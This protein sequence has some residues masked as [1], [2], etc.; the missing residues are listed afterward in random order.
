MRRRLALA[1]LF[2]LGWP[3]ALRAADGTLGSGQYRL[4]GASFDIAP[5]EQ[6]VPVGVSATVKTIFSGSV[7]ALAAA[8]ARVVAELSGPGVPSPV[9]I[10]AAPGEDLVVPSLSI[11]GEHRLDHIRLT[12]GT[13]AAVPAAH[14]T[15]RIVVSDIFVTQITS[16]ALTSQELAARGVVVND[17]NYKA[18]SFALGLA[19]QGRTITIE[20]P[21]VVQTRDGYQPLGPPTV[22][23]ENRDERFVPPT[24]I[25][26][27]LKDDRPASGPPD[28]EEIV[29]DEVSPQPVFGLL[30]FPGNI[31]F[32]NQFFSVVLMVQNGSAAGSNLTLHDVRATISRPAASLRLAKTI[33]AVPDGSPVPVRAAGPDGVLGTGDDVSVLVAQA[34]G[35]AEFVTEGLRVGTHEV[36]CELEATLEGLANQAPRRLTGRARGSVLVR[37]PSFG[38][39]FNHPDVIRSGEEYELRVTVANTSTVVA[40]HVSISIDAASLTGA[41]PVDLPQGVDPSAQLGD[42]PPGESRLAKFTLRATRT[43]RV[44]ASAFTS[45]GSVVGSLRLRTGVTNDGI[46]LSPDSFVF[47][48]FVSLLPSAIVDPATALIG[49]AHGLATVDPTAPGLG[50][51]LLGE[52]CAAP[53]AD[54]VVRNRVSE[55]VAA[56]RRAGLGEPIP[57]A[58]AD[59]AFAWL[60]GAV[61]SPGFDGV[62][63]SNDHGKDFEAGIG[64]VLSAHLGAAGRSELE[65]TLLDAA[66]ANRPADDPS[67]LQGGP[68]WAILDEGSPTDPTARLYLGDP[69][70]GALSGLRPGEAGYLRGA[71]FTGLFS[72]SAAEGSEV[73]IVAR[74]RSSGVVLG[75][76]GRRTGAVGLTVFFPDGAGGFRRARFDGIA[77]AAGSVTN[78]HVLS[79]ATQLQSISATDIV[80]TAP[81][82]EAPPS[83]FRPYGASQDLDANPL[84]KAVSLVFNRPLLVGRASEVER[85][86]L[87]ALR[88]DGSSYERGVNGAFAQGSDPRHVILVSET[89][90]SP[91]RPGV[92]V[93]SNVP[94]RDGSLW[95][96]TLPITPK[97]DRPGGT[98]SGRV[99]GPDGTPLPN[100]QVRLSESATD[101][102]S[103]EV[104]A[105]TTSVTRTDATGAFVFDY[106]RKQDGRPFR[107]DSFDAL[108]GSKGF[109][110]G[111]IRSQGQSVQVDVVLQGRGTVRGTVVDGNGAVLPGVI[112]RCSSENDPG[113]RTAQLSLAD[114]SF[115][116]LS[117]PVGAVRLQAEDPI[118]NRT[119]YA[120]VALSA[121]GAV[122]TRQ[123]VLA[124]LPRTSL[125]GVVLHGGDGSPYGNVYVAG[126]GQL[127]EYFGVRLTEADGRF[128]FASA[129]AGNVRLELFDT[130]ISQGPILVQ[131]VTLIGDQPAE[132]TLTFVETTPSFGTVAGVVR[133]V[134][135]GASAPV[136]GIVVYARSTG[137]RTTTTAEGAYRLDGIPIGQQSIFALDPATGRSVSGSTAVQQGLISTLD[138]Q[139]ADATRGSVVG[140]VLDQRGQPKSGVKV[141]IFDEGPPIKVI[142][143]AVTAADGSFTLLD[144]PPGTL[145]VQATM[146]EQRGSLTLRNAGAASANLP[147]AG[148]AARVTILLRGWVTVTG[149]VVARVRDRNGDLHDNPVFAPVELR[150]SRFSDGLNDPDPEVGPLY[151]DGP[152]P[153]STVNTD[154]ETGAFRFENVHGGPIRVVVRNPF[155]GEKAQDLGFVQGDTSRGPVELAFD[156][157]LGIV[158]GYLF[159]ADGTPIVGGHLTLSGEGSLGA[160]EAT[161][162]PAGPSNDA[163]YFIFPLV[164]FSRVIRLRFAEA[165]NG[166]DRFAEGSVSISAQAPSARVTLRALGV[167]AVNVRVVQPSGNDLVP[168]PGAQVR[169][170]ELRG[171]QRS[172]TATADASGTATFS[173]VTEGPV[174]ALARTGL[175]SGRSSAFGS[176]E[177]FGLD[178]VVRITGTAR[179]LGSVRIP[180]DGSPAPNVNIVLAS[181][182]GGGLGLGPLAAATTAADGS[183]DIPDVPAVSG[184]VY[185]VD[186]EDPGS[187]RRGQSGTL[188]LGQGDEKRADITLNALGAVTGTLTTFD[189]AA[190]IGG[191]EI[192]VSSYEPIPGSEHARVTELVASTD[193]HGAYRVDGVP[194]GT[195][196]VRSHDDLTGLSASGSGSLSAEGQ[197]VTIDLRATPTGRVRGV[198][199]K[200]D[201]T[202]LDAA[203]AAPTV[204]LDSSRTQVATTKAYDFT[205]VDAT[206]E[207]VLEA[208]EPVGPFHSATTNGSVSPGETRTIDLRYGPFG[209]VRVHL[210]KPDPAS[211]GSFLP[212]VGLVTIYQGGP[213]AGRFPSQASFRTDGQ[214]ELTIVNVGGGF[215]LSVRAVEDATGAAG[216]ANVA[217]FTADGQVVDATIVVEPRGIVRGRLL[218]PGG[219]SPASGVAVRLYLS[220]YTVSPLSPPGATA[221]AVADALGL[222]ELR[223][224]PF[225]NFFVIA[226]TTT[227]LSRVFVEGRLTAGAPV[228]DLGDLVLDDSAP[229]LVAVDPP[230]GS[231]GLGLTPAI[232]FIFSEPLWPYGSDG[233]WRLTQFTSSTGQ[234]LSGFQASQ[235]DTGRIVTIRPTSPLPGNT[236]FEVRLPGN[237]RDR[238]LLDVGADTVTRFTTADLTNP[239]VVR[240][241]PVANQVQVGVQVNPSVVLSKAIDPATIGGGTHL[242]RLDAPSGPVSIS[243]AL[244][245]DGRTIVLNASANLEDE[246]EY[247]IVLDALRDLAGNALHATTRI[248]FFTRDDRA[249]GPVFDS[250]DTSEPVEGTIHDYTVRFADDDVKTV[251]LWLVAPTGEIWN[252]TSGVVSPPRADRSVTCTVRLPRISEAGGASIRARTVATDFGGNSSA[253]VDLP[254]TLRYDA[255]PTIVSAAA[256]ASTVKVG[257]SFAVTV[258]ASD[259]QSLSGIE[260]T[261][262]V[263]LEAVSTEVT[264]SSPTGRTEVRTYRAAPGAVPGLASV[265]F[266]ARDSRGQLSAATQVSVTIQADDPPT[267]TII[268]PAA[269]STILAGSNVPVTFRVSD[270]LGVAALVLELGTSRVTVPGPVGTGTASLVAPAVAS[271]QALDLT[272][273]ATDTTGHVVRATTPVTIRPDG[274]PVVVVTAPSA[275]LHVKGGS[276]VPVSGSLSDDNDRATLTAN[277][278]ASS[279]TVATVG[280][281][282]FTLGVPVVTATTSMNLFVTAADDTGHVADPVAIGLVVDP[283]TSDPTIAVGS[284]ADGSTVIGGMAF[285]LVATASDDVAVTA[286]R[287]KVNG[288]AFSAVSGRVIAAQIAAPAVASPTP[289]AIV[290]EA[291]DGAGHVA[292]TAIG[293]TVVPNQ[294]PTLTILQPTVDA[295]ITAG[296][297]F[298]VSGRAADDSGTPTTAVTFN[299]TTKSATG[300]TFSV[301]FTAPAVSTETPATILASAQDPEGN[302]S[303]PV[304]VTV[305]VVPDVGGTPTIRLADSSPSALLVGEATAVSIVYA[306]NVGL[307]SGTAEVTGAFTSGPRTFALS[308][309]SSS[310][311]IDVVSAG[312]PFGDSA[313]VRAR[314]VDLGGHVATLDVTLPVAY[315]R[316]ELPLP[317]GPVTEGSPLTGVFRLSPSGRQRAA[318]LRLEIGTVSGQTFTVVACTQRNAPLAELETVFVPVPVGRTGL[319]VRSVLVETTGAQALAARTDGRSILLDPLATAGDTVSPVVSITSPATGTAVLAGDLVTVTVTASDDTRIDRIDVEFGGITKTCVVSPC[320]L[321]FFAPVVATAGPR[322][323]FATARDG[324]GKTATTSVSLTVSPRPGG[325]SKSG[326][327]DALVR[328][329]GVAPAIR[330]LTPYVSPAPVAPNA[331][332][333]PVFESADADGIARIE[334]YLDGGEVPCLVIRPSHPSREGCLVPDGPAGER[335][336]LRAVAYDRSGQTGAIETAIVVTPG[337]RFRQAGILPADRDVSG[338]TLYVETETRLEA[339]LVVDNLVVRDGGRLSATPGRPLTVTARH[340]VF[341]DTGSVVSA[342]GAGPGPSAVEPVLDTR[343]GE[344]GAHGGDAGSRLAFDSFLRPGWPGASGGDGTAGADR[345]SRGGGVIAIR[346]E[347]VVLAGTVEA[348]GEPQLAV[349]TG[350]IGAGGSVRIEAGSSIV[351]AHG[352]V[353]GT[354]YALV[355]ASGGRVTTDVE[356]E[357]LGAG[358]RIALAAPVVEVVDVDVAGSVSPTH[359]GGAGTVYVRDESHTNGRLLL[360]GGLPEPGNGRPGSVVSMPSHVPSLGCGRLEP[361]AA[362]RCRTPGRAFSLG[363]AGLWIEVAGPP[364]VRLRILDE[365]PDGFRLDLAGRD[366]L[367]AGLSGRA[368]C[369][370]VVLD[371]LHMEDGAHAVF[372]DRLEVP[373]QGISIDST[374]SLEQP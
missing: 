364:S 70:T 247:E 180:A 8:G 231:A 255:P 151:K 209:S 62:R 96:G 243:P 166:I 276:T 73:G 105:A 233:L 259:D 128:S 137:Q 52:D 120:T 340:E 331:P 67:V 274:P 81:A 82:V 119:A 55:L 334:V 342:T 36:T 13:G 281:F 25:A 217:D 328:G 76:E 343:M 285:S 314:N 320:T 200:A 98:V 207:F 305:T 304:T 48:R 260:A 148:A 275:G 186:A 206:R 222:F 33:P 300:T 68:V 193:A 9:T 201:G 88:P 370:V 12:D 284:P 254:L 292:R 80:R 83:P 169:I 312:T 63:R 14:P 230:D 42:L 345:G 22:N 296:A 10:S 224:V 18:Y 366:G 183:F 176:G 282:S 173:N 163:G 311:S 79:G 279:R 319:Y 357:A 294:S 94:G 112:V 306:D 272:A 245:A 363:L 246:A 7:Q 365:S 261:P 344:G 290:I 161:T 316:L 139:F 218:R 92:V 85:Y 333:R 154:P 84:G 99:I 219:A 297:T 198:V 351:A 122:E 26:V 257:N 101:D 46:P 146:A 141:E 32:L 95:S 103:G 71:P 299:G 1:F 86:A 237:L 41:V 196:Q 179:V 236:L 220:G 191:A 165:V 157:N 367:L 59:L 34:T 44:V 341:L 235:D 147:G 100:A 251:T 264:A 324:A 74:P 40:N 64:A 301:A 131:T 327:A 15:A 121:P 302:A 280:A 298:S 130:S 54:G 51:G 368:Y 189:G 323:L 27:P 190:A 348:D 77:T 167:G 90:V 346:A 293:I 124:Q 188:V 269:G 266:R 38:L 110:V 97:L 203:A 205:G 208:R 2:A 242:N 91:F 174:T 66:V 350:G 16:R 58:V 123:L 204:S 240:S 24:V 69:A 369:G 144:V 142:G 283:D 202:P 177:G 170:D 329:D 278:G 321:T 158:D 361:V 267:V 104:F 159:N 295:R 61:S 31:R 143:Q 226:D 241:T 78:V 107:I 223:D 171:L 4:I 197:V 225:R 347:R 332:F 192:S 145:R 56:A 133:K 317:T 65:T 50:C 57:A 291:E 149:R 289:L 153:Y 127:G 313:R 111:S 315:H 228:L 194:A 175:F 29:E 212:A 155:Y 5:V 43:G 325:G 326:P 140:V 195:I 303:P 28:P 172:F 87:P 89:I 310:Q 37:D 45:D 17:S 215:G 248:P 152:S 20:I 118:T 373:R 349:G 253:P 232:R 270:D 229:A 109:A 108:T 360:R 60:G 21:T 113:F 238:N 168:V 337:L 211:P 308:G 213:Y 72:V 374:S 307:S 53:F 199:R 162:R 160:M 273:T 184:A 181:L 178:A 6:T 353:P 359:A 244:Q 362:D 354:S 268:S 135:A 115:L 250:P 234:L 221:G 129:P 214:G 138:L 134:V 287:Y 277:L 249:P 358:G 19:V 262:S 258:T 216:S 93:G 252:A 356:P 47:P 30:V 239:V 322:T 339:A 210:R 330:F 263:G 185:R 126:Y 156:G 114:G 102:L 187:M 75:I 372:G 132:V 49:I 116:F 3:G 39:T 125:R 11:K 309:T 286:F 182:G 227:P 117:V 355:T 338:E 371:E 335:H 35:Q 352:D 288:G 336:T 271:V 150:S 256:S 136:A 318:A 265:S 164:P 23:V 106:V